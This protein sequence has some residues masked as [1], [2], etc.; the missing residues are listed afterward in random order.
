MEDGL[1]VFRFQIRK[2]LTVNFQLNSEMSRV[3]IVYASCMKHVRSIYEACM[4]CV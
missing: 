3:C 2:Q 1:S 4:K